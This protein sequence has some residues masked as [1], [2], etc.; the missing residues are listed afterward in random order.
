MFFLCSRNKRQTITQNKSYPQARAE[1]P[2]AA[3]L[4]APPPATVI[5]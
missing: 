2:L 1:H 4:M 5:L 3:A